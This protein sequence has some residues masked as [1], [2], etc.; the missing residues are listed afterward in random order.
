MIMM[1]DMQYS[2]SHVLLESNIT[3]RGLYMIY[4]SNIATLSLREEPLMILGWLGQKQE[5]NSTA[6]RPGKNSAQ[7]PRRKK[8]QQPGRKKNSSA[9]WPG[10]KNLSASWPGKKTQNEFSAPS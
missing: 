8:I 3:V 1:I 5:K 7:Q 10:K 6:T 4:S 9:G 2:C